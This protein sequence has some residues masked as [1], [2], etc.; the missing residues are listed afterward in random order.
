MS[1]APD[2][3]PGDFFDAPTAAPVKTAPDTLPGDFFDAPTLQPSTK[4]SAPDTLPGD[5]FDSKDFTL[6]PTPG[7]N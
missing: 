4:S 7:L 3:L 1:L 5:F 6:N 2:T